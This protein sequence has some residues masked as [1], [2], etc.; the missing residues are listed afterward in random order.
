MRLLATNC[1]VFGALKLEGLYRNLGYWTSQ[2]DRAVWKLNLPRPGR[3]TVTINFA[4]APDAAGNRFLVEAGDQQ[5]SGTIRSTGSWDIYE[6]I[7]AGAIDLKAGA[8][9][10]V[11]RSDGPIRGALLDL[12]SIVLTPVEK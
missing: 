7:D 10:V 5:L 9:E 4:C 1:E 8:S 6:E 3:Y 2:T 11:L 12:G